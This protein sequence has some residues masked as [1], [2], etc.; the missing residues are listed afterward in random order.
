[1]EIG[2]DIGEAKAS[3]RRGGGVV[4]RWSDGEME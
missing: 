4:E 2:F 3:R 1:M